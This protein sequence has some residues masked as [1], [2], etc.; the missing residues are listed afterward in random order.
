MVY[1]LTENRKIRNCLRD[2][3]F[4]LIRTVTEINS[5]LG[6]LSTITDIVFF[7]RNGHGREIVFVFLTL[8]D[9]LLTTR[10][11]RG[12]FFVCFFFLDVLEY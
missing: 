3:F 1:H 7:L 8:H 11:R 10:G 9:T 5:L 6:N 12:S 4:E 2:S